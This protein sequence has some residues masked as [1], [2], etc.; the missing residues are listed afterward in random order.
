MSALS[1]MAFS[2]HRQ[3]DILPGDR[4]IIS[5]SAIPGNEHSIG[6]VINELYRKDAEVVNERLAPPRVGP[7]LPGGA[8]DHPRLVKPKFFIPVHGE[9]RHLKTHAKLAQQM[10]MPPKNILISDIGKVI[11]LTPNSAKINAPCPPGV[12]LWTATAWATWVAWCCATASTWPR[13]A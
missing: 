12:C 2:T 3:V 8:E 7:R 11:E 5:A 13:T 6:N 4:I 9:Q 10:G 1:R